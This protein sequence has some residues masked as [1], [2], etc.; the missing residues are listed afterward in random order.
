AG[1]FQPNFGG[2][3]DAFVTKLNPTGSALVYSSYL[4]GSSN[5]SGIGIA[6]DALGS[7]YV[8][9]DT[10]SFNF[11]TTTG[12]FQA[13]FGGHDDAFVAKFSFGNTTVGAN[14]TVQLGQVTL[15][16]ANVTA[17]GDTTLTTSA[18]GPAPPTGFKLGNPPT[19]Y[20]LATTASFSGSVTV[21]TNYTGI[22]FDNE[23][24]LKLSHFVD[25]NWVDATPV[26]LDTATHTICGSVTSLSPFAI[27]E[28]AIEPFAAFAAK[29]EIE[30]ERHEREFKVK[31]TFT[32]GAGSNGIDP[33]SEDVTL[34]VGAFAATIHAGSFHRH[35]HGTFKFEGVVGG[36]RLEVKIQA[37]GGNRFEF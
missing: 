10:D 30:G 34:Q 11:P 8:T 20:N 26:S 27:F 6:V 28:P 36:A 24:S 16:F 5:D 4:G 22:A 1:A 19:Y 12:A 21:C 32:L 9:G 29:V 7:A 2:S 37:R 3:T 17:A 18:E 23:A 25:P 31:G 35:E 13:A 15:T 33:R 14:V